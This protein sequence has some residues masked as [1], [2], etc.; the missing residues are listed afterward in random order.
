MT[1]LAPI[2]N[3]PIVAHFDHGTSTRDV[4]L[5]QGTVTAIQA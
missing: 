3:F 2:R 4:R 1:D 5:M